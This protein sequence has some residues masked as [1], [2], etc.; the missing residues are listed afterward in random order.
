MSCLV[1]AAC[2]TA[3]PL[4]LLQYDSD[5]VLKQPEDGSAAPRGAGGAA[6]G[7]SAPGSGAGGAESGRGDPERGDWDDGGDEADAER[8]PC[9]PVSSPPSHGMGAPG[10]HPQLQLHRPVA[11]AAE[12]PWGH[13]GGF[14]AASGGGGRGRGG[15]GGG[16]RGREDG[17]EGTLRYVSLAGEQRSEAEGVAALGKAA[18]GLE[19]VPLLPGPGPGR[20]RH[21][22]SST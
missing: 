2:C 15:D 12:E 18:A 8:Q 19:A 9:L 3:C 22:G 13:T 1:C 10:T 5:D 6:G 21:G 7:P 17:E 11:A 20:A 16:A 14:S 4:V